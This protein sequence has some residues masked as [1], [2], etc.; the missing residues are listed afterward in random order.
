M[1]QR[2]SNDHVLPAQEQAKSF[3][4]QAGHNGEN[5]GRRYADGGD[6][7]LGRPVQIRRQIHRSPP[8]RLKGLDPL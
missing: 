3:L 6:V 4:E 5:E 2:W 8:F 7:E 1:R